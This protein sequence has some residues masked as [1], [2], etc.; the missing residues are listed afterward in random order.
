LLPGEASHALYII[1]RSFTT[2]LRMNLLGSAAAAVA[3]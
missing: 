2:F 1:H 3:A